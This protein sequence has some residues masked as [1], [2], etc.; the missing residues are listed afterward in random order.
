MNIPTR[1]TSRLILRPLEPS[2]SKSLYRIFCQP[3]ILTFFPNPK[4]P[5]L[6]GVERMITGQLE[7]WQQYG[8]GWWAVQDK[9]SSEHIG[10]CG[11]QFLPETEEV[12]VAY[13]LDKDYWGRGL[14]TEAAESALQYGFD[15]TG[16]NEIVG[17]VHPQ[18]DASIR[19]LE[20][21]GMTFMVR[22]PYFGMDCLRYALLAD[23]F[24]ASKKMARRW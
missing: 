21:I 1:F 24:H 7:H 22:K 20:K 8:Y 6:S 16:E 17:I 9:N 5:E 18:N 15:E 23:D 10:W 3:D 13:L 19:V 11:L 12:E 4:P 2:D 14:A